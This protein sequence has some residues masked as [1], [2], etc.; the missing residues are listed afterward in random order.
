M[1]CFGEEA[2]CRQ[3]GLEHSR[4]VM[5]QCGSWTMW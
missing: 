4:T 2:H 1:E 5:K 3:I